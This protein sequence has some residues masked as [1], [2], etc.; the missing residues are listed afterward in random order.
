MD[1][2]EDE[3]ANR[4]IKRRP[5]AG[6]AIYASIRPPTSVFLFSLVRVVLLQSCSASEDNN[7][8]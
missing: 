6:A 3:K 4:I 7:E 2:Q 8:A 5:T 1:S